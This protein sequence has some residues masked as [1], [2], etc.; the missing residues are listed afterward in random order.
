MLKL[1][2]LTST[3][4]KKT[5]RL[6]WMD[7]ILTMEVEACWEENRFDQM[8]C[9][10]PIGAVLVANEMGEQHCHLVTHAHTNVLELR[11]LLNRES[12]VQVQ[13][14]QFSNTMQRGVQS[15]R[16]LL[17]NKY[18][19]YWETGLYSLKRQLFDDHLKAHDPFQIW[20]FWAAECMS[21][22]RF[23]SNKRAVQ[24]LRRTSSCVEPL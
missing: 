5:S 15:F 22:P 20:T 7:S 8:G 3:L 12:I 18:I 4:R 11:H 19:A 13:T 14:R 9:M 21:A 23:T 2:Q 16:A 6:T 1:K 10:I 24:P 17:K